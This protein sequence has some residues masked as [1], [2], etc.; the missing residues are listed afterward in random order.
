MITAANQQQTY[1]PFGLGATPT[2]MTSP[3]LSQMTA[4]PPAGELGTPTAM[5]KSNEPSVWDGQFWDQ[6]KLQAGVAG[7]GAGNT[8][9]ND[10]TWMGALNNLSGIQLD[11]AGKAA[12]TQ[13]GDVDEEIAATQNTYKDAFGRSYQTVKGAEGD[14]SQYIQFTDRNGDGFSNPTGNNGRDRV[15][16]IYKLNADGT[17]TPHSANTRYEAGEWNRSG[18]EIATWAAILGTAGVGGAALE[19][20]AAGAGGAG[21]AG[22]AALLGGEGL[23]AEAAG[24]ALATD[25]TGATVAADA[26]GAGYGAGGAA[27]TPTATTAAGGTT[28]AAGGATAAGGGAAA[29]GGGAAAGGSAAGSLIPGIS[30][31]QLLTLG[32]TAALQAAN[33]PPSAPNAAALSSQQSA[34]NIKAAETSASINRPDIN[35]PFG[36]Q[37]WSRVADPS[38]PGGFRYIQNNTLSAGE[39]ALYDKDTANKIA[40]QE[41][42]GGLQGAA[43]DA[44][45]TPFSLSGQPALQTSVANGDKYASERDKVADAVYQQGLRQLKPGMDQATEAQDSQ[46]RN[47]GLLPGTQAYDTALE[48]LRRSQGNQLNDLTDRATQAGGAEQSRLA[49]LDLTSANFANNARQQSIQEALLARTQPLAELNSFTSGAAPTTPT[50]QP[51]GTSNVAPT[52]TQGAAAA[53]QQGEMAAYNARQAQ[54]QSLLNLGTSMYASNQPQYDPATGQWVSKP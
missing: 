6:A 19:A 53:Q 31:S 46:L 45:K 27:W 29:S 49:G 28:A 37:T 8:I 39:Q 42:A 9:A 32:G 30:N 41:I 2:G 44:V 23:G 35:T 52:N 33:K 38:Q 40:K 50:F 26:A 51:F 13:Y 47:Q 34:E 22:E 3:V 21:G 5:P 48:N 1:K 36:S 16:P 43:A 7:Q 14:P 54:L 12:Y 10:A 24:G 11:Q 17:A 25:A 15:A 18:Q 4:T 20:G